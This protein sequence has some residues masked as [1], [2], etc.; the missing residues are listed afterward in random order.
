MVTPPRR[1]VTAALAAFALLVGAASLQAQEPVQASVDRTTVRVNE[2]FTFV[3]RAEGTTGGEPD[4]GPLAAQFDILNAMSSRRIGIV[5]ARAAEVNE[6][7]YQLMPK[8]AGDFTI[9]P[10]R[11]GNRQSNPVA[12]RVLALDPA[13]TAAADVFMELT[14]EPDIVYAQSQVL[15]TLR[16]Y[17][18]VTTGRATLTAPET[19]GV[20]AIVEKLGEDSAY[21]TTRGGR[22]FDV[23]ERRYAI[24][25]QQAGA[26]TIGP[27]TYEAMVIPDRGFSRVQR[28]RS[29]VLELTVQPAVAPPSA[30]AGAAWLPALDVS[31]TE[32]WSEPGSEL[33][34][35][36]PRTRTI[37]VE[38][39]GLLDT[40]LPE[41]PLE[42][43][44]GVRQYADRPELAREVTAEGFKSRRSVSYAVI[45]QTPGDITLA[46][47]KL[48]W[49]NVNTQRWEV[50]EL[51]PRTLRVAPSTDAAAAS[52]EVAEEA[53]APAPAA[54]REGSSL[55]P[56]VTAVFAA[57]WLATVALWW[58][59]RTRRPRTPSPAATK[60]DAKPALRKIL[61]DLASACSVN[62]P[63][64]ARNA[65]LSY[66]DVQFAPN[67]PRS[68]GALAALLSEP[69]AREVLALEA[70]IYG[71]AIGAWRGDGLKAVLAELESGA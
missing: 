8:T 4:T 12:V 2:S 41:V 10:L 64:A 37:V 45:A 71:A 52:P 20:E 24:F 23:R 35:G 36:I 55:W 66:A 3:L 63:A 46:A 70:H 38:G 44:A 51:P 54:T 49:W 22:M 28:F 21:R 6:W 53:A 56:W 50:A 11:I 31:L 19:T 58:R 67:S 48:P 32:Q 9:P 16:L 69:V 17:V 59:A 13:A 7:Q 5:N 29:D 1:A 68:L 57:A 25:P 62:D 43:Q 42:S 30:L 27:V 61:R 47:I 26:L 65:L 39:V 60:P 18:G 33:A 34:V 40:Q 15:F 14:A